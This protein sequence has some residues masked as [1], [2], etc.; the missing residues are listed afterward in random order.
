MDDPTKPPAT[1]YMVALPDL[2]AYQS[3]ETIDERKAMLKARFPHLKI[4]VGRMKYEEGYERDEV[5]VIPA[6]A[7]VRDGGIV[8][9]VASRDSE[10]EEK[11]FD[12]ITS[13]DPHGHFSVRH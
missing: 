8:H 9:Q 13:F 3:Q 4:G 7:E 12:A 2:P 10:T 11:I 5:M 1:D 6:L